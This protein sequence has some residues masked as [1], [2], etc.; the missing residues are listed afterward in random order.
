LLTFS[1]ACHLIAIF[2]STTG[3][4]TIQ[5]LT[6]ERQRMLG[7]GAAWTDATVE[8]FDS[9]SA[10]AQ[11]ALL[12]ELFGDE[13]DGIKIELTRHTAGQSD[14][15][16]ADIGAYSYDDTD[17]DVGLE[18]FS[19][20]Q[21]GAK[22]VAWLQ[23]MGNVSSA[24][25]TNVTLLGSLWSPPL[26]M[27]HPLT[28][29]LLEEYYDAYASYVVKYVGAFKDAGVTVD[30][31][32]LQ[33]EP[34][35][36][37]GDHHW[38]MFMLPELAAKL[39]AKVRE[40][41]DAGGRLSDTR[42]WAFDHN[43]NTPE[44]P[45]RVL[46][47]TEEGVVDGVAWH[48]YAPGGA[49]WTEIAA[50]ETANPGR[51]TDTQVMTECWLHLGSGESFFDL[52][53]FV[54]GPVRNGAAGAIAWILGGSDAYDLGFPGRDS[55]GECSGIVQV[56]MTSGTYEKT[57]DYYTLGQFSKFV[58]KGAVRLETAYPQS[59]DDGSATTYQFVAFRNQR[60]G[61]E[62]VLVV[63]NQAPMDIL[64]NVALESGGGYNAHVEANSVTTLVLPASSN[65][66]SV[67]SSSSEEE[68]G[69]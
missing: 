59:D 13:P 51:V 63:V 44:Y 11:E 19:L 68:G 8:A 34:L 55:C 4:L 2:V 7:F 28:N 31:V 16:P 15:T 40:G 38:T 50:F 6:G 45:Q 30:A 54:A 66:S 12:S 25:G 65:S 1:R 5:D 10:E 41:L 39:S 29:N 52:P 53:N 67:S 37:E 17:G 57:Q 23:R 60:N 64:L 48:C 24:V 69:N 43:T 35:H 47:E 27:K 58:E 18:H 46:D 61:G 3:V 32:T 36:G 42:I 9:L 14:L 22:M 56:N 20:G 21:P 49:N 33:N 62:L 26:W